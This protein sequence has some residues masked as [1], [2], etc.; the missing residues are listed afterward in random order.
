MKKARIAIIGGGLSGLY[1]AFL[2]EQRGIDDYVLLEARSEFGGRIL[3]APVSKTHARAEDTFN[4]VDRFDLGPTWF[5]PTLQPQL[6]RLIADLGLDRLE[7]HEAGS[8]IIERSPHEVPM[9]IDSAYTMSTPS[10][11]LAGGMGAMIAALR[12]TLAQE[13]LVIG[14]AVRRIRRT[15]QHVEI[16]AE[17]SREQRITYGV[18]FVLLAV[19]PR[20]AVSTIDFIPALPDSLSLNWAGTGTWMASHAKYVAVYETPFWRDQGLSGEARSAAGPLG[21]IHDASSPS[22]N[23][24]LFGFFSTPARTRKHLPE[25][26]LRL[27]CRAQLR[28]IFGPQAALP[29]AEL[30]KDWAADSLT[31]TP[32]DL[33]GMAGHGAAPAATA[34]SGPWHGCLAGIAS[35][36]SPRFPGYVAGAID[37]ATVSIRHALN[38]AGVGS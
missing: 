21:E 32:A 22:G 14:H 7:Q 18:N 13:R 5:W 19:P 17:N 15:E 25:E 34:D 8:M 38:A 3:S 9:R 23:G 26:Q 11:R 6:D 1:A 27:H 33:D 10:M 4:A 24:A 28:R 35:E 36:W 37:A 2:L 29:K 31:A 12:Q 16:E 30:I 20:L